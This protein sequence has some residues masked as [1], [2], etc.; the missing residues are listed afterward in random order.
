MFDRWRLMPE[1]DDATA[2]DPR[3]VGFIQTWF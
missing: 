1:V 3:V 2:A